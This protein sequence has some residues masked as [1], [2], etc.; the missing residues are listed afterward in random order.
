M[1]G[2]P[3]SLPRVLLSGSV[4]QL[5]SHTKE[6][7]AWPLSFAGAWAHCNAFIN[8]QPLG[9]GFCSK[10]KT[11]ALL[12]QHEKPKGRVTRDYILVSMIALSMTTFENT[13][14][15]VKG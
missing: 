3:E 9:E 8:H 6:L 4:K 2:C 14:L 15:V 12:A 7:T 13:L 10:H 11:R 5:K 1:T